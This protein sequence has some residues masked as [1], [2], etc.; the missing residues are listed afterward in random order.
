MLHIEVPA[1]AAFHGDIRAVT[2]PFLMIWGEKSP[3]YA[4]GSG[5]MLRDVVPQA[6]FRVIDGAGH[7]IVSQRPAEVA[8]AM[9][10]FFA[11]HPM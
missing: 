1:M 11:R 8:A 3:L 9:A 4:E 10:A 5:D 7:S 6:E 2:M